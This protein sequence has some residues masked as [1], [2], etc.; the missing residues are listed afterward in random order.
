MTEEEFKN[1]LGE[2]K[3]SKRTLAYHSFNGYKEYKLRI[4]RNHEVYESYIT[5]DP[6]N[7]PRGQI[8]LIT[9]SMPILIEQGVQQNLN[10]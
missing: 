1:W 2:G 6:V 8:Y 9:F 5:Y 7:A 4:E 3:I 10:L